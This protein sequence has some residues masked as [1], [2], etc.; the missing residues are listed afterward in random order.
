MRHRIDM[1]NETKTVV[2]EIPT[3]RAERG[4]ARPWPDE[5]LLRVEVEDGVVTIEGDPAGLR[6]LAVQLLSLA[7]PGVPPGYG[8]DLDGYLPAELEPGSTPLVLMRTR[9]PRHP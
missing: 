3:Y 5:Y 9:D 8:H 4:L 2:L 6:G 1:E 7:E